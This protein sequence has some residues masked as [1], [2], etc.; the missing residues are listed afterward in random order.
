MGLSF[1]ISKANKSTLIEIV[2]IV[3]VFVTHVWPHKWR[4]LIPI[5]LG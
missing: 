3:T 5:Q 1:L 2:L 4:I